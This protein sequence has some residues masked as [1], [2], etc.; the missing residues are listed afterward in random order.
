MTTSSV[1]FLRPTVFA[2]S[3]G[4][5]VFNRPCEGGTTTVLAG[6]AAGTRI[7]SFAYRLGEMFG[8]LQQ[9]RSHSTWPVTPF[10]HRETC[11]EWLS[12]FLRPVKSTVTSVRLFY[13]TQK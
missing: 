3:G 4:R 11:P 1:G 5:I 9:R 10:M 7:S 12:V 13:T 2:Q 6:T 8:L